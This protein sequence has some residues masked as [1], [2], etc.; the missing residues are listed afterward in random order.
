MIGFFVLSGLVACGPAQRGTISDFQTSAPRVAEEGGMPT[1][2]GL[3]PSAAG[4]YIPYSESAYQASIGKK[5]VFFFHATW[6]PY[7]RAADQAFNA[8]LGRIPADVVLLKTDYDTQKA[9][10]AQYG[11]TYQHT[12]VY[13][14]DAG[15]PIK[16]WNGGDIE[17]LIANSK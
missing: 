15:N 7:C 4:N 6:C 17:E 14:D 1:A 5:R 8:N 16:I 11:I 12:F 13:V 9:L 10:K 2:N 3:T